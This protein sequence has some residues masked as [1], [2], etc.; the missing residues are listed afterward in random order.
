MFATLM[1]MEVVPIVPIVNFKFSLDHTSL[2]RVDLSFVYLL[3]TGPGHCEESILLVRA[4]CMRQRNEVAIKLGIIFLSLSLS[5]HHL[6]NLQERVD[7]G[8]PNFAWA[9]K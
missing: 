1:F 9:P 5:S 3:D 2:Y 6:L 7:V 8:F 4:K